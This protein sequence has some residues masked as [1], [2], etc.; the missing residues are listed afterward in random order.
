MKKKILFIT[1]SP[2]FPL[3][4]GGNIKTYH[5]LRELNKEFEVYL[6]FLCKEVPSTTVLSELSNVASH[7]TFFKHSLILNRVKTRPLWLINNYLHVRPYLFAQYYHPQI[8]VQL[9]EIL[10]AFYPDIIHIDRFSMSQFLPL[11]KKQIWILESQNIESDITKGIAAYGKSFSQRIFYFLETALIKK[12]EKKYF[13]VFDHI[14]SLSIGEKKRLLQFYP[15][16]NIT[17][18]KMKLDFFPHYRN[19]QANTLNGNSLL[20]VGNFDWYPNE[21]GMRW[22]ISEV[23][24]LVLREQ[25][26]TELHIVGMNSRKLLSHLTSHQVF[27]YGYQ[28]NLK[29]FFAH[30]S[31]FVSPIRI[32]SGIRF[33]I[34]TALKSNLPVVSTRLGLYGLVYDPSSYLVADTAQ[35]FA[36][37]VVKLLTRSKLKKKLICNAQR[38]LKQNFRESFLSEYQTII[39]E[40]T[41]G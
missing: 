39:D 36:D 35:E 1:E 5:T 21:D 20:F 24:P 7:V 15:N 34:L 33:K 3:D 27:C 37:A 13:P 14:F 6:F 2:P 25:P 32:A 18:Q 12:Q 26:R 10:G 17:V 41:L 8:K 31:I 9:S 11:E 28:K 23:F 29:P 16:L 22:F 38:Y 19:F 30:A 40:L 4:S